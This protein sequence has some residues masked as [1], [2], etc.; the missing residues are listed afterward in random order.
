MSF[1]D[2]GGPWVVG[3]VIAFATLLLLAIFVRIA[4]IVRYIPNDRLGVVLSLIHI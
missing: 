4:G 3:L 2:F 1:T